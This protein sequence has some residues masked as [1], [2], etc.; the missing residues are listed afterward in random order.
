MVIA[1]PQPSGIK[2]TI[3]SRRPS[4]LRFALLSDDLSDDLSHEPRSISFLFSL[5]F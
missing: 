4:E 5:A 2:R 3:G 1:V